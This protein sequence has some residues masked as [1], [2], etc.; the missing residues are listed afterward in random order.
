ML[1]THTSLRISELR[2][3]DEK[4][5][6]PSRSYFLLN[7]LLTRACNIFEKKRKKH[8]VAL[9]GTLH[10]DI[11]NVMSAKFFDNRTNQLCKGVSE[12]YER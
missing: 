1:A 8:Y 3:N 7:L 11:V 12:F 10:C 6:A 2:F 9:T 5:F 4:K